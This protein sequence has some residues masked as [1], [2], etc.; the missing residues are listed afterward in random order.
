MYCVIEKNKDFLL[1]NKPQGVGI[2]CEENQLGFIAE[3]KKHYQLDEL[4]PVHRL[5]KVTSGLLLC[6]C[7]TQAASELSQL[8]QHRRVEKYYFAISDKKPKKKQG[9][10]IG[11]MDKSRRGSWKLLPT[12]NNP[13]ITQFFSYGMG[14][15][16]RL[17]I[18]KPSTGKT[19]QLRVALKSIGAPIC[20]DQRYGGTELY[21]QAH[22]NG[23]INNG[24]ILLHAGALI[25]E[26]QQQQYRYV[27]LP[28][29]WPALFQDWLVVDE[30]H[31][32]MLEEPWGLPW[33]H[34]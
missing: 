14:N 20:G 25:F 3:L 31:S 10:I 1:V 33:P 15:Q 17:F 32:H 6:A 34:R 16:R 22:G 26:Y 18:L 27:L 8:F 7:H 29:H 24:G 4:Y 23:Q 9:A 2:H 19:H 28:E 30:K 12:R 11:D 21:D 5:D 13:A